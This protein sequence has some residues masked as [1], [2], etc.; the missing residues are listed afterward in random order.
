MTPE[1]ESM[2]T[3]FQRALGGAA[4]RLASMFG[5]RNKTEQ[6]YGSVP[7]SFT[8]QAEAAPSIAWENASAIGQPGNFVGQQ[9]PA[10]SND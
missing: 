6:S 5:G 8:R 2:R 1:R 9:A 7:P 10:E 4:N 3:K